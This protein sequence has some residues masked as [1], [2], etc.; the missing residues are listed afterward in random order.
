MESFERDSFFFA[1]LCFRF[2]WNRAC[3]HMGDILFQ[4]L[5]FFCSQTDAIR[6]NGLMLNFEVLIAERFFFRYHQDSVP[7]DAE[8]L[9]GQRIM[10]A[11]GIDRSLISNIQM[12]ENLR[13]F[14][15]QVYINAEISIRFFRLE[16]LTGF[17]DEL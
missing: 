9:P 3:H 8:H 11:I 13:A 6:E 7:I 1:D 5:L 17:L 2:P 15:F 14:A 10:T 12:P 4:L 16:L